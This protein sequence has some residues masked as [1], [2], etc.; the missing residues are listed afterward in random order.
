MTRCNR[1]RFTALAIGTLLAGTANGGAAQSGLLTPP[2][3]HGDSVYV[4]LSVG[5][6]Q[7]LH[8]RAFLGDWNSAL[9]LRLAVVYR[10]DATRSVF[11]GVEHSVFSTATVLDNPEMRVLTIIPG[12]TLSH[13]T[14]LATPYARL[15]AGL[16]RQGLRRMR[17]DQGSFRY[18]GS[19]V[20]VAWTT[21]F[22]INGAAGA[23]INTSGVVF[24]YVE[25]SYVGSRAAGVTVGHVT[26]RV[27]LAMAPGRFF[28]IIRGDPA[29]P[30]EV[31][32]QPGRVP[33]AAVRLP[34]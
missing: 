28:D 25:A 4:Y 11:L 7:P 19:V 2:R 8:P 12:L 27:G 33:R 17:I 20:E 9:A 34:R 6:A 18:T 1:A 32:A 21:G 16:V 22:A 3:Y 29:T 15:G 30:A 26:F 14:N 5:S 23:V 24:P 31:S 10:L 13:R